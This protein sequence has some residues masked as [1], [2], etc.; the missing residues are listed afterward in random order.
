MRRRFPVADREQGREL[1]SFGDPGERGGRDERCG[2]VADGRERGARGQD[3]GAQPDGP[4]RWPRQRFPREDRV[5]QQGRDREDGQQESAVLWAAQVSR[6]EQGVTDGDHADAGA[7]DR[8][9][10]RRASQRGVAREDREAVPEAGLPL[11]TLPREEPGDR[12]GRRDQ[13][14]GRA[15]ADRAAEEPGE[16]GTGEGGGGEGQGVEAAGFRELF[17]GHGRQLSRPA[18]GDGRVQ[19]AGHDGDGD[20][21]RERQVPERR[22]DDGEPAGV[23]GEC[24]GEQPAGRGAAVEE[25]AEDG[26]AHGGGRGQPGEQRRPGVRPRGEPEQEE[27]GA[28]Q[29]VAGPRECRAGQVTP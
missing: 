5:G 26:P 12:R 6:P 27:G 20:H 17:L 29:L 7:G 2:A 3:Q 11:G 9:R 19:Q 10:R 18:P 22:G 1:R 24:G 4:V 15:E 13:D 21:A 14:D 23:P 28:G 8:R 16:P 25:G